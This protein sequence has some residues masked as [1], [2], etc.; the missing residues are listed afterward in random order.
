MPPSATTWWQPAQWS[1]NS[2]RPAATLAAP[3]AAR[4]LRSAAER[5]DVARSSARI[6]GSSKRS[7][8]AHR[9]VARVG[10]RHVAGAQVEVGGQR[11]DAAQR[12]AEQAR[13]AG[14][15][16]R[17]RRC[18]GSA[19]SWRRTARRR[20][21]PCDDRRAGPARRGRARSASRS[22]MS[23]PVTLRAV[24]DAPE[25]MTMTRNSGPIV[26]PITA[27]KCMRPA[28]G[29]SSSSLVAG[30]PPGRRSAAPPASDER[31]GDRRRA[32]SASAST[33][34]LQPAPRV[35]SGQSASASATPAT[36]WTAHASGAPRHAD[37]GERAGRSRGDTCDERDQHADA[38]P[39]THQ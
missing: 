13:V 37:P 30:G 20:L 24:D 25:L 9:L 10:Q 3:G 36:C 1:V 16:R 31:R 18:R 17:A 35:L 8:R 32:P 19:R 39:P 11:A 14:A 27:R 21:R 26:I 2:S 7:A 6:C 38:R 23:A 4:D 29:A 34:T 15:P 22:T 33:G 28:G 5:G 12:R